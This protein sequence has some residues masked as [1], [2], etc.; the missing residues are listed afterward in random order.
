MTP[1]YKC[2]WTLSDKDGQPKCTVFPQQCDSFTHTDMNWLL[3]MKLCGK[4]TKL[5]SQKLFSLNTHK[6]Y[7]GI[8][9]DLNLPNDVPVAYSLAYHEKKDLMLTSHLAPHAT[10][11]NPTSRKSPF[12]CMMFQAY[13][14]Q[15]WQL[16]SL[17]GTVTNIWC[18]STPIQAGTRLIS[19]T[20]WLQQVSYWSW[21]DTFLFMG[22][23]KPSSQTMG[24][25]LWVMS[26]KIS[27][28]PVT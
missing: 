19:S 20:I 16:K 28:W 14:G 13:H 17:S 10:A 3:T 25:S 7:I 2:L 15:Q 18:L 1:P 11:P 6:L 9:L 21:R 24:D 8:T 23:L 12:S 4:A 26:L 27:L 22:H 5:S